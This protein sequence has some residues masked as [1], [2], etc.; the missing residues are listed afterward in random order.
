MVRFSKFTPKKE[1]DEKFE[2]FSLE[3]NFVHPKKTRER[4]NGG[5]W[6]YNKKINYLRVHWWILR[7]K[8]KGEGKKGKERN[9]LW[10]LI[11]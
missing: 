2:E 8:E 9:L 1:I 4:V 5:S 10:C 3:R 6:N 7:K 11:G